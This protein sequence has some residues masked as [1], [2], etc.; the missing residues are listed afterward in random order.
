MEPI[1]DPVRLR[2]RTL[3]EFA[4]QAAWIA[5]VA[6][7]VDDLDNLLVDPPQLR[8]G[9]GPNHDRRRRRRTHRR[10]RADRA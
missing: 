3:R 4:F 5:T 10:P 7:T 1:D 2:Q 9:L 8:R 6:E